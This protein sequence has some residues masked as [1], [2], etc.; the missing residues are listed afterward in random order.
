MEGYFTWQDQVA[1]NLAEMESLVKACQAS[2]LLLRDK[3]GQS[4]MSH[5]GMRG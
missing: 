1:A 5:H 2:L 4:E 3:L